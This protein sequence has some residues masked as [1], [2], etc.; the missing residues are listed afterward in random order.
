MT[1]S[2]YYKITTCPTHIRSEFKILAK[3][4]IEVLSDTHIFLTSSVLIK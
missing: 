4:T 3:I 2:N 1:E